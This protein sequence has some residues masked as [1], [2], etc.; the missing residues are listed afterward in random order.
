MKTVLHL[1]GL[2][3]CS[4][5]CQDRDLSNTFCENH[6]SIMIMKPTLEAHVNGEKGIG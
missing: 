1:S 5:S 3:C 4:I 2:L 6:R